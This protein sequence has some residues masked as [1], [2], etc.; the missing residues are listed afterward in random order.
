[1]FTRGHAGQ[2][3]RGFRAPTQT[4]VQREHGAFLKNE[5][6]KRGDALIRKAFSIQEYHKRVATNN[7]YRGVTLAVEGLMNAHANPEVP[8]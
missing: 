6:S 3:G 1:M 2:S 8:S 4:L 5:N 7:P